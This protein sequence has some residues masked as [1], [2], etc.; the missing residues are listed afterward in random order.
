M[1]SLRIGPLMVAVAVCAL[2]ALFGTALVGES[3]GSWYG[4]LDKPWFLIPQRALGIVGAIY[5]VP[6]AIV[7]YRVLIH[8]DDHGGKLALL[9]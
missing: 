3:L 2:F 4:A 9:F 1:R 7:L 8:V 5:Y 6:F